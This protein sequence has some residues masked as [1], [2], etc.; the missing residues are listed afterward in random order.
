MDSKP[1][2]VLPGEIKVEEGIV[3]I[4]CPRPQDEAAKGTVQNRREMTMPLT[5]NKKVEEFKYI[6][7]DM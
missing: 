4:D 7:E 2:Q 3:I 1:K 5:L 6:R